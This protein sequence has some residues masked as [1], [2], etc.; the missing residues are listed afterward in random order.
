MAKDKD[1]D[2][3]LEP[4]DTLKDAEL[5]PVE[6][7]VKDPVDDGG[8]KGEEVVLTE[9][10]P[11]NKSVG[12][13][14]S[15]GFFQTYD[16]K[17]VEP[18]YVDKAAEAELD[19]KPIQAEVSKIRVQFNKL[20]PFPGTLKRISVLIQVGS[21][22]YLSIPLFAMVKDVT[23]LVFTHVMDA[24]PIPEDAFYIVV[25]RVKNLGLIDTTIQCDLTT[26]QAADAKPLL[27]K[28]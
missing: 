15:Y 28:G 19:L 10:R 21:V 18:S 3:E 27:K 26:T 12:S 2:A 8:G 20:P 24:L 22:I 5:E 7:P 16:K 9:A 13:I 14:A 6:D 11:V 23:G 4:D 25:V 1:K 17:T